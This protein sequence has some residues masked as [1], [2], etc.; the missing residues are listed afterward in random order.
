MPIVPDLP[1][2]NSLKLRLKH[3][4]ILVAKYVVNSI[5]GRNRKK[6]DSSMLRTDF[7]KEFY[8]KI[9][10]DIGFKNVQCLPYNPYWN[11]TKP[12]SNKHKKMLKSYVKDWQ[13]KKTEERLSLETEE[14]KEVC[15][16]LLCEK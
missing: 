5:L 15:F 10:E 9:C 11:V 7:S 4:P 8:S 3:N 12:G 2:S 1:Y 13:S 14:G 16:L 6:Q